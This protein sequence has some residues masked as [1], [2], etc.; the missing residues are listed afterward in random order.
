[1]KDIGKTDI[2]KELLISLKKTDEKHHDIEKIITL[3]RKAA[4]K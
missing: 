4:S 2:R 3:G 1:L